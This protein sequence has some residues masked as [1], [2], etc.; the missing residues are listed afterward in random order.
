MCV[1]QDAPSAPE[2]RIGPDTVGCILAGKPPAFS[3]AIQSSEAIVAF[4]VYFSYT[5]GPEFY[6]EP[7]LTPGGYKAVL[8]K[9]PTGAREL[10]YYVRATSASFAEAT[11]PVSV[12]RVVKSASQ[13]P[14]GARLAETGSSADVGAVLSTVPARPVPGYPTVAD[15]PA[16]VPPPDSYVGCYALSISPRPARSWFDRSAAFLEPTVS[17]EL[18]SLPVE[19]GFG[20]PDDKKVFVLKALRGVEQAGETTPF[21]SVT[22]SG[23]LD[24]VWTAVLSGLVVELEPSARGLSGTASPFSDAA[25]QPERTIK[26]SAKRVA[27]PKDTGTGR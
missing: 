8:P 14:S 10:K 16:P 21:W 26:V 22:P 9:P 11:T 7:T 18:T 24:L 5:E 23:G 3:G 2:I 12:A 1:A 27:C 15:E 25:N 13:C 19:P 20:I 17:V 4:R 6:V